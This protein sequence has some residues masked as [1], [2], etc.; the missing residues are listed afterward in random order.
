M[1][2]HKLVFKG[3]LLLSM[4]A[5]LFISFKGTFIACGLV[6]RYFTGWAFYLERACITWCGGA[7]F[8]TC[9]RMWRMDR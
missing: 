4:A 8:W 3:I 5:A 9:L 7:A 1:K 2:I 6:P